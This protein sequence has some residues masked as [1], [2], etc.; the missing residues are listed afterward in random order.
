MTHG[1]GEIEVNA[2]LLPN[3]EDTKAVCGL[4]TVPFAFDLR[5]LVVSQPD[6]N[7][8]GAGEATARPEIGDL[9]ECVVIPVAGLAVTVTL[10]KTR[11]KERPRFIVNEGL[12]NKAK[13][14]TGVIMAKGPDA[15][16]GFV[17]GWR[18]L[19]D[20]TQVPWAHLM[21]HLTAPTSR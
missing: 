3:S 6:T 9:V 11:R 18:P 5:E 7:Q 17:P 21:S 10:D 16:I 19:P 15:T 4:N 13:L 8:H 14:K 2:Q 12:K 1:I 20:L